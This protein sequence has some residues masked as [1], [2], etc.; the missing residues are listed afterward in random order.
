MLNLC[1]FWRFSFFARGQY[2]RT[3][4]TRKKTKFSSIS[5]SLPAC[6]NIKIDFFYTLKGLFHSPFFV[7]LAVAEIICLKCKMM[8]SLHIF[9]FDI[10]KYACNKEMHKST[11]N[12]VF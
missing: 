1:R 5:Q 11:H 12:F 2:H 8:A 10:R 6:R 9:C 3:A 7:K 4:P